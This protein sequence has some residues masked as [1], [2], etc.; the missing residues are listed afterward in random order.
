MAYRQCRSL[1]LGLVLVL[2]IGAPGIAAQEATPALDPGAFSPTITN[3]LFPLASIRE[4]VLEG[5]DEATGNGEP[6][7]IRIEVVVLKETKVIAGIEA[8]VVEVTEYADDE[9]T[10]RTLDYYAQHS[11]GTV[12][13]LGEDV[14]NYRD[15]K[16][17]GHEGEWLAGEGENQ[18]GIYMPAS[19]EVGTVFEQERAPG[20]AEDQSTVIAID[21][22]VDTPA[23]TFTGCILVEDLDP[24]SGDTGQKSYCPGV[25]IASE[26]SPGYFVALVHVDP[27]PEATPATPSGG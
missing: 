8:T 4:E 2:G 15:G 16:L 6:V 27:A 11:D 7:A 23:G 3:P 25:G 13:Y 24:L 1:L 17:V 20:V 18:A 14:D 10:E 22:T 21:E 12:Y 5:E 19:V 26:E 9:V